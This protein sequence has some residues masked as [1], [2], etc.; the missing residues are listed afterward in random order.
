MRARNYSILSSVYDRL[1]NPTFYSKYIKFIKLVIRKHKLNVN[2]ILDAGCGTGR[3]SKE[4]KKVGFEV[5]GIDISKEMVRLAR[6]RGIKCYVMS[7]EEFNI[8]KRFDMIIS[9]YDSVNYLTKTKLKKFIKNAYRHLVNGGALIFDINSPAKIKRLQNRETKFF[10]TNGYDI[11][12]L[13]YGKNCWISKIIIY[14]QA[15]KNLYKKYVEV[16]KE[17]I[18]DP[19]FINQLLVSTG[20]R[21]VFI[22]SDFKLDSKIQNAD[23]IFFVAIK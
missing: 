19:V 10:S 9:T 5:V 6:K 17:Y 1:M 12:W 11:V 8:G 13:S 15:R 18:H 23:R 7:M 22:Y 3:L 21:K 2:K 4:L 14:K 20:F 16:H